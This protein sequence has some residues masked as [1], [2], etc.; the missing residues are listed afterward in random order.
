MLMFFMLYNFLISYIGESFN[1]EQNQVQILHLKYVSK[2]NVDFLTIQK[3]VH[4]Q[5]KS[6]Y[7][8]WRGIFNFIQCI[9]GELDDKVN[10]ILIFSPLTQ[11]EFTTGIS[12][13]NPIK[14]EIST[15]TA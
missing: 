12:S 4:N 5:T 14:Q 6:T 9:V 3:F 7:S 11:T 15:V 1:R 8:C 13:L 2:K 10:A